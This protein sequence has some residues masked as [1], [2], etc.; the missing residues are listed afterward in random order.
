MASAPEP[1]ADPGP[2]DVQP[3]LA[4]GTD[5]SEVEAYRLRVRALIAESVSPLMDS[6]EEEHRFPRAAVAA[7]GASGILRER[8]AGPHGD[9]G[10]GLVYAEELGRAL[11]GGIGI[12]LLVQSENVISI[13]RRFGD[14]DEA[15]AL[16]DQVLD[17]AVVGCIAA[18]E[19]Q[20]GADLAAVRT[21]AEQDGDGWR[22]RGEKAYSSP[23]GA[24]DFCMALCRLPEGNGFF[25]P[26][27]AIALV[28]RDGFAPRPLQT[29]GLWSLETCRLTVD[30][31][32]P[33]GRMLAARGLGLHA[34]QWGLTFERF[35]GAV[36]A[37]GGADTTLRLA[38]TH[39]HRRTQFGAP[40]FEHQA[41]RLRIAELA[42]QVRLMRGG[43]YELASRW[44]RTDQR[45]IREAA[46]TKVT[47]ARLGERVLSE[48]AHVFGGSGYL[49][50][51]TPFPRMLRD[52]RLARLG[53]GADEMMLE[54]YAGALETDDD[55]YDRLTSIQ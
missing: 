40:L 7:V 4:G 35:A 10:R 32:V 2:A 14:S 24:A 22:V 44:E 5:S 33:A 36:F 53:G 38:I 13:L 11:T 29:A 26:A 43:L 23:A 55:L 6:A 37:I 47:A 49:E 31:G 28:D 16:L 1:G 45:M 34:L 19:P 25:E 50:N 8:W 21:V 51:E 9:V 52:F 48:C 12:G 27:L 20:G 17:G 46:A 18:S 42:A 39:L 41:L 30:A 54:L 3:L 15:R